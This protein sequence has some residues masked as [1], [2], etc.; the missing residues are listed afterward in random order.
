MR[1]LVKIQAVT[2]LAVRSDALFL[3]IPIKGEAPVERW[4]PRDYIWDEE[5]DAEI[6]KVGDGKILWIERWYARKEGFVPKE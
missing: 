2:V 3:Q 6:W 1:A 4:V 5:E